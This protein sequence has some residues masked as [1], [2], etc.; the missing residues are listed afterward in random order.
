MTYW[1]PPHHE[2]PAMIP[3]AMGW[4]AA[5]LYRPSRSMNEPSV[6]E[7]ACGKAKHDAA[8]ARR[9]KRKRGGKR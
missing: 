8:V 3:L 1:N 6:H 4:V 7:Y 5:D 2:P 9:K